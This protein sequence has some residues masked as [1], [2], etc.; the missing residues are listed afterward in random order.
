LGFHTS[1]SRQG[2]CEVF[3]QIC[4]LPLH[5][6]TFE[7]GYCSTEQL[8]SSAAGEGTVSNKRVTCISYTIWYGTSQTSIKLCLVQDIR[9][10]KVHLQRQVLVCLIQL[11]TVF[12]L[13]LKV[14]SQ[15]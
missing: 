11:W 8:T 15:S 10:E 6:A 1:F 7:N 2:N 13:V 4:Q 3:L 14:Q 12:G 5:I 9:V